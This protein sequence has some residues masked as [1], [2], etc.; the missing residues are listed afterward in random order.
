[1]N[2][3]ILFIEIRIRYKINRMNVVKKQTKSGTPNV[4]IFLGFT[5]ADLNCLILNIVA[6]FSVLSI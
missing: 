6:S 4:L 1:M 3:H 5:F 2:K